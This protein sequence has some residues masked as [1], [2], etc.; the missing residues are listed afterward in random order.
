MTDG[1]LYE[2]D[3]PAWCDLQADR[4]RAAASRATGQDQPDWTHVI[5]EIADMGAAERHRVESL[6]TQAMMHLLKL[7]AHPGSADAPHW[8]VETRVFLGDARRQYAPSMRQRISLPALFSDA[9]FQMEGSRVNIPCPFTLDDLLAPSPDV[10]ALAAQ[11][12]PQPGA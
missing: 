2:H 3:F 5:E 4:L 7:Q 10:A 12:P 1:E 8:M 9:I 6:L 11:L